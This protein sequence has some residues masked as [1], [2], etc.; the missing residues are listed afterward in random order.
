[1]S[2]ADRPSPAMSAKLHPN[3]RKKGNDGNMY[4]S[5][6]NKNG[7]YRWR[8]AK[9]WKRQVAKVSRRGKTSKLRYYKTVC[10]NPEDEYLV[11]VSKSSVLVWSRTQETMDAFSTSEEYYEHKYFDQ[12]VYEVKNPMK[13]MPGKSP[14]NSMTEFSG[15]DGPE[16]DGNTVLI[17]V[18]KNRFVFIGPGISEFT[19]DA[20][21]KIKTFL[22]PV[23]NNSVPYPYIETNKSVYLFL[24]DSKIEIEEYRAK[25]AGRTDIDDPYTALW[26]HTELQLKTLPFVMKK[27]VSHEK[28]E[29]MEKEEEEEKPEKKAPPSLWQRFK[30]W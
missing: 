28:N 9:A 18:S 13:V 24:D 3:A 22:S 4:E 16:F 7:V 21:E 2:R 19:L 12:L 5:V 25:T 20:N 15:G 14:L 8:K 10:N 30:F 1:M 29:S 11:G 27:L 6:V 17:Q 26:R 23:G